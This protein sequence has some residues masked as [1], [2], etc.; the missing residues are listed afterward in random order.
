MTGTNK[1]RNALNEAV[2]QAMGLGGRGFEFK[3]LTRRD[4]TQAERRVASYY[5]VDDVIQPERDYKSGNLREGEMYRVIGTAT[6]RPR[7][8]V[9][10]R[11]VT[12]ERTQFNPARATKLSVYQP[13][14]AEL[15]A[16]DL[17]RV[18]R[19][20]AK[21]DLVNGGR[22][23]VSAVTPTTVTIEGGGRRLTLDAGSPLHLD[24]AYAA[25]S[26]SAQGLTCDRAFI[27]GESFSR[28]TQ[29]DVYYVAISRARHETEI[30]TNN[31]SRLAKAVDR[32]EESKRPA[33]PY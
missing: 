14:E 9:V 31:A 2:L 26:H 24:R 11:V 19:N 23:R 6:E 20:N 17:V 16:G 5:F 15:A 7:D 27:N 33:N 18:T 32:Q 13:V 10:E 8:L 3:V 30:F 22:L 21:L 28:T 1:S 25:T 12:K 4:T 29:R